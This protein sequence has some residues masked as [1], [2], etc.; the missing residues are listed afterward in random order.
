MANITIIEAF[1]RSLTSTKSYIDKI[2]ATK[3]DKVDGK[4][5]STNDLTDI[6]KA[7][8]DT[9]YTHSQAA[10][11]PVNAQKNSDITKAEIEAKLTG[12]ITSH[13]HADTLVIDSI[14]DG[15]LTLTTDKFQ[16][17]DMVNNTTI[18][19]PTVTAYTEIHL[20]FNTAE[21]LSL[22][23]PKIKWQKQPE[24]E[25]G[26]TY[27]LIFEYI[28]EVTGWIGK[29]VDHRM[30]MNL[31]PASL[32]LS[33]KRQV[34]LNADAI[35][36]VS[37]TVYN[38]DGEDITSYV[39][40]DLSWKVEDPAVCSLSANANTCSISAL[41]DGYTHVTCSCG[42]LQQ[43]FS[44][45][46]DDPTIQSTKNV[47]NF[48]NILD[49]GKFHRKGIDGTG[50]K[51]GLYGRTD[52][53]ENMEILD[54]PTAITTTGTNAH[55]R[56]VASIIKHKEFGIAPGATCYNVCGNG[57]A[58][59]ENIDS[60]PSSIYEAVENNLD[61]FV[62]THGWS[63][64]NAPT[65]DQKKAVIE[66]FNYAYEN[67]LIIVLSGGNNKNSMH[68]EYPQELFE[69]V[70]MIAGCSDDGKTAMGT[71]S[72]FA[73]V[74]FSYVTTASYY[75]S[76]EV[77]SGNGTSVSTPAAAGVLAL[78]LQ[79]NP[80]F[81]IEELRQ[82][83]ID[84]GEHLME[85]GY[86]NIPMLRVSFVPDDYMTQ[87]EIDAREAAFKDIT[88][89]TLTSVSVGDT[90][91]DFTWNSTNNRWEVTIPKGSTA[92]INCTIEPSDADDYI[93][94]CSGNKT[95]FSLGR[96]ENSN[97]VTLNG[98]VG[99]FNVLRA[100]DRHYN[101]IVALKIITG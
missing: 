10:H 33:S 22:T 37:A 60:L 8:Y 77:V 89:A 27:E 58:A 45:V 21:A 101:T 87:E 52:S 88:S 19:L 55:N 46:Y 13:T 85:N 38:A 12:Q 56:M 20:Y 78:L 3:V 44:Y 70:I 36:S 64:L 16:Y 43:S 93:R 54:L 40:S 84:T 34:A 39:A 4:S 48:Y 50:V 24:I 82:Y 94:W 90:N 1:T 100:R 81:T 74:Y 83:I 41:A 49:V 95:D 31:T 80:D 91:Y 57:G 2:A 62:L 17:A 6:L 23:L 42:N 73:H 28:N 53:N 68:L 72:Y 15:V 69:K 71:D 5:L 79:Q 7:N 99:S 29:I 63:G 76:F 25:A 67:G 51:I 96:R 98:S 47:S 92:T 35:N 9:A 18:T 59:S 66:A 14:T 26:V 30:Y 75:D 97:Q 65:A 61:I 32:T 86:G 11:A